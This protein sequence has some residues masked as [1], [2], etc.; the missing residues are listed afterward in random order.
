MHGGGQEGGAPGGG[1]MGGLSGGALSILSAGTWRRSVQPA[2]A[3]V[4]VGSLDTRTLSAG[5]GTS[6]YAVVCARVRARAAPA[7]SGE[8]RS[9]LQPERALSSPA[10]A[11]RT[12]GRRAR[13]CGARLGGCEGVRVYYILTPMQYISRRDRRA[14]PP[15]LSSKRK[16]GFRCLRSSHCHSCSLAPP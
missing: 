10:P 7:E 12:S 2:S 11:Q 1:E 3:F 14:A 16:R 8:R 4:F 9:G 5:R 6:L 15:A 13:K